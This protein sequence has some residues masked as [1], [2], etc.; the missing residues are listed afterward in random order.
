MRRTRC[1]QNS[2]DSDKV[3]PE[4]EAVRSRFQIRDLLGLVGSLGSPM[5]YS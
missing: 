1:R 3:D 2:Q 4:G 5:P